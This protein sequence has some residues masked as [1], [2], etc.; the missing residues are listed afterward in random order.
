MPSALLKQSKD[1]RFLTLR[2]RGRPLSEIASAAGRADAC[3]FL[4]F[5]EPCS[6]PPPPRGGLLSHSRRRRRTASNPRN[7]RQRNA[8]RMTVRAA[9]SARGGPQLTRGRKR[10]PQAAARTTAPRSSRRR[11][12]LALRH[13]ADGSY[14]G[15]SATNSSQ[16]CNGQSSVCTATLP[17][18]S[19]PVTS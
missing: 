19:M 8:V 16:L 3:V 5:E 13:S 9:A 14:S 2:R 6:S 10:S 7:G 15:C 17:S 11:T 12:V 1:F 4:R 18:T